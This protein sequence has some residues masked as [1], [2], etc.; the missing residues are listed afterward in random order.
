MKRFFF[1]TIGGILY[2]Y[3]CGVFE[4]VHFYRMIARD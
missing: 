3:E 4:G 1:M 2:T